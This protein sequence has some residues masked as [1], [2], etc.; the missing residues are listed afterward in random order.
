MTKYAVKQLSVFL[1]NRRGRLADV[2]KVLAE[3]GINIRALFLADSSEFGILRLVVNNPE[4]AKAVLI[5]K[6][7][8]ANETDVFA[9][10]VE[11]K[12]GGFYSVI[13]ILA[14]NGIDVE[15][16]YA[17]AG[18]SHTA[19]LFFKVKNEDFSKALKLLEE[20]GHKLIEAAKFYE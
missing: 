15:Y 19:I 16:T 20:S 8:A 4:K 18:A 3:A 2:A 6:G 1:E 5:S 13:K 11:D 14:E 7:F 17:Y 9:V 12:P 10:E